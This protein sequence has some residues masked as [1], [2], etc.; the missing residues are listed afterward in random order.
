[1]TEENT[2]TGCF[3]NICKRCGCR[4]LILSNGYCG[5]CDAVLFGKYNGGSYLIKKGDSNE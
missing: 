4:G 1:M 3:T 5:R 2:T